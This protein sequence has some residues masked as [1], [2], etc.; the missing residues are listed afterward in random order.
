MPAPLVNDNAYDFSSVSIEVNTP[1]GPREFV[2][3]TA[4]NY[5]T[6]LEPGEKKGTRA[7]SIGTTKGTG[8]HEAS[9][10]MN[11]DDATALLAALGQGFMRNR[12]NITVQYADDGM[13]VVTDRLLSVRITKVESGGQNGSDAL[14]KKFTLRPFRSV[15]NGL[16]PIGE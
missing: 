6:S 12:F 14:Q 7:Q 4:I 3:V 15:L 2:G 1:A 16:D 13:P 5:T 9:M 10:D 11:L 8:S